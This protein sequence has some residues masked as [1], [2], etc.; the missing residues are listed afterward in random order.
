MVPPSNWPLIAIMPPPSQT[1]IK[2]ISKRRVLSSAAVAEDKT[3]E[4]VDVRK[5]DLH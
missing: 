3:L 1:I 4:K 2:T 5:M